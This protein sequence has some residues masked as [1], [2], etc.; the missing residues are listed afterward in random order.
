M[1]HT[2][3]ELHMV[4]R[5]RRWKQVLFWTV[6]SVVAAYLL[7]VIC[8]VVFSCLVG[9]WR[10]EWRQKMGR[11]QLAAV[12]SAL[13][14]W[15]QDMGRYPSDEEG[16]LALVQRPSGADATKWQGPYFLGTLQDPWSHGLRYTRIPDGYRVESAGPDGDFGTPDDIV[17]TGD[18]HPITATQ[19]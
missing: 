4:R 17:L 3:L 2:L 6:L 1:A 12:S 14:M 11:E 5:P 10:P 19:P 18:Q 15:S 7:M 9:A 13:Q 16:L 8:S